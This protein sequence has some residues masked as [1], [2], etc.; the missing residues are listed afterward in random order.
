MKISAIA[1]ALIG[2]ALGTFLPSEAVAARVAPARATTLP[3]RDECASDPSFA[4]FRAELLDILV[5]RDADRL[6]PIIAEDI[7]WSFGGDAG[8]ARFVETWGLTDPVNS[9]LWAELADTLMLGCDRREGAMVS[10]YLS[11]HMPA[12]TDLFDSGVARAG[13]TLYSAPDA[14]EEGQRLAWHILDGVQ[15]LAGGWVRVHLVD[16]RSGYLRDQDFVSPAGY[17]AHFE[18]RAGEWRLTVFIAGD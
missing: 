2:A 1:I 7:E 18:K 9:P 10:P 5:R 8:R 11:S 13:A 16:G 17:R 4:A 6:I 14:M 15:E 3:P 12:E